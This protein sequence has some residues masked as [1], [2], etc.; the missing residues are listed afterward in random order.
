VGKATTLWNQQVQ[1]DRTI[2]SNK[3]DIMIRD[4]KKGTCM[5][6]YVAIPEDRNVMKKEAEKILKC[7]RPHNRNTVHVEC[8]NKGDASN[9]RTYWN[10]FKTLQKIL[11]QHTGKARYE[12]TTENSYIGHST[13]T[14]ESAN[15][16]AHKSLILKTALYAPLTLRAE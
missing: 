14:S 5:L 4:N 2:P 11:E 13:H 1:T 6:I 12:G 10:H 8:R 9:N 3:P 16:E 7:K 15:V